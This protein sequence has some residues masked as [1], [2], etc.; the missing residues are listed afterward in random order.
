MAPVPNGLGP[1]QRARVIP[2]SGSDGPLLV[3]GGAGRYEGIYRVLAS[4]VEMLVDL[5][6]PVPGAANEAFT[7]FPGVAAQVGE[8]VAFLGGTA[9]RTGAY[10]FQTGAVE[11]CLD[12]TQSLPGF[13][14]GSGRVAWVG[15]DGLR[16]AGLVATNGP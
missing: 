10:L 12:S 6:T 2:A 16:R 5:A 15:Y 8:R 3:F 11:R 14:P 4:G 1:I 13:A 7:R 9:N